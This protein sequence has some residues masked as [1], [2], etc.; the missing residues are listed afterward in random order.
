MSLQGTIVGMAQDFVGSNNINLLT[1][2]GQFGTRRMGGKDSASPRYIFTKL[3]KITRA[4]FHPDDDALLTY[5]NDDGQSIEPEFYVPVIPMLLVNGSDGIGTGWSTTIPNF[6]PREIIAN[7]RRKIKGEEMEEMHPSYFG[8]N[9][10]IEANPKSVGSYNVAGTVERIDDET[11]LI[12]E[13]PVKTWTQDYKVFLEKMMTGEVAPKKADAKKTTTKKESTEP[14]ISDFKENHTDT[15]V[16]FTVTAAKAFIDKWESE[17]GGLLAK[18]KLTGKMATSNMN[19]FDEHNRI[20]KFAT[21][22]RIIDYFYDVRLDY[23]LLR[24]DHM[25]THMRRE[26]RMLSNKARFIEEVCTGELIVSN[27]K[28][29]H[30]LAELKERG[31]ELFSKEKKTQE[32]GDDEDDE[33][34]NSSDAEL[35]KGYEYLLGMK[36]WSLT[37][38]KA[39]KI[40]QELAE[41]SKAVA[42][43][44]ATP[45]TALWEADL[46]SIEEALDERDQ[47]HKEAGEEE[48]RSQNKATKRR[49]GKKA[50]AKK[51]SKKKSSDSDNDSDDDFVVKKKSVAKKS[52]KSAAKSSTEPEE[53]AHAVPAEAPVAKKA[54]APAAKKTT[55]P[56]AKYT[57]AP[58]TKKA[59]PPVAK[60]AVVKKAASVF[61]LDDSD[62]SDD[63][64]GTGL[65][66]RLKSNKNPLSSKS[67]SVAASTN[68]KKRPSPRSR[69]DSDATEDS[70]DIGTFEPAAL[71]PA[72][73]KVRT[74]I[75]KS[76]VVMKPMNLDDSEDDNIEE[77]KQKPK[78]KTV[79]K[80]ISTK[81]KAEAKAKPKPE[82]KKEEVFDEDDLSEDEEEGE[83]ED[84]FDD[85]E[86]EESD[87]EASFVPPPRARTGR[88]AAKKV[89]YQVDSDSDDE[90]DFA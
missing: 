55:A 41:K 50:A 58:V 26:Q 9:G 78:K 33:D 27:R 37:F 1:P 76:K 48:L 71:T 22:K 8:F 84:D 86:L 2:S 44:E 35:A 54:T 70:F 24:K 43:L 62:D 39:N 83:E 17:T 69:S 56:P 59:T 67:V 85:E 82:K 34:D 73:K 31:Y 21:A 68:S 90:L 80:K 81:A 64:F 29:S 65:M 89:T 77:E 23:Y 16:S 28:R 14:E 66:D 51:S 74:T 5:L 12:S 46:T 53:V 47:F 63:D 19:A 52:K 79:S 61:N 7:L 75:G 36:I 38:E 60:K 10:K 57:T 6:A 3:E 15:T 18:F 30:I 72:P 45:P 49:A 25:L 11:I 88:G 4:I 42:E 87:G 13:L 32:A 40:R 20:I